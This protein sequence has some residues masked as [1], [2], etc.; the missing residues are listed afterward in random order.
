MLY[1]DGVQAGKGGFFKIRSGVTTVK[2]LAAVYEQVFETKVDISR[3]GSVEE[4]ETELARLRTE[5]GR[6][7][8]LEYMWEAAA[9]IASKG[10]WDSRD[11]TVL[12][13]FKQPTTLE[14]YLREEGNSLQF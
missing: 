14:Q 1:G 10:L 9:V 7:G 4:L 5:K 2:E 8:Y 12:K 13:Q 6:I 11:V 3:E